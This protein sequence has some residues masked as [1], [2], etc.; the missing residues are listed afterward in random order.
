MKLE[1]EESLAPMGG[2][3]AANIHD[4]SFRRR[5]DRVE[6]PAQAF[7][8]AEAAVRD[9]ARTLTHPSPS[10]LLNP[11]AS[12]SSSRL[13]A[14]LDMQL[15]GMVRYTDNGSCEGGRSCLS[16]MHVVSK[17]AGV[18]VDMHVK[19]CGSC[20]RDACHGLRELW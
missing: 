14:I 6:A 4:G 13:F 7:R 16:T 2:G 10:P 20:G 17:F 9:L 12:L 19:F 5:A 8:Q 3:T 11:T 15:G 18:V 1:Q